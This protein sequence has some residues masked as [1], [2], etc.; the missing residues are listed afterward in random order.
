MITTAVILAAGRGTR[1]KEITAKRSKAMAP[2]V[3]MPMI[4][5]VIDSLQA[6]GVLR[7][8]VVAAPGD[9]GLKDFFRASP[10]VIVREQRE[11]RGSG[12][13]LRV[14]EADIE[15]PF[16]VS[17]CDSLLETDDIIAA[18]AL[19]ESTQAQAALTVMQVGE[20]VSLESRSVVRMQGNEVLDFIEKPSRSQRVSNITSLPLWVLSPEIFGELATLVPS[21]RGEYELPATFNSLIA[22]GRRV[23]A[24]RAVA[25]YD[26][27][28]V[29]D[30]LSLNRMF[31]R[32]LSPTIEVHPTVSI[33]EGT[34]LLAPVR[35]DEGC[36]I[37]EE[38]EL[39]PEVYL[40]R[41]AAVASHVTLRNAVVMRDVHV[42]TSGSNTV[43]T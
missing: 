24:H 11:P 26:L 19:F 41:G 14:C 42:T 31:L 29:A 33:P 5:R 30:L 8:I 3:G 13:A 27:T 15:G 36:L 10:H 34:K 38:V 7:F 1:L 35:I 4:A 12:D 23:V 17:A 25:R 21:P 16:L 43:Y 32:R 2:I 40:E 39:G 37:G 9:Q 6:A 22:K 18:C 20:D 28:T